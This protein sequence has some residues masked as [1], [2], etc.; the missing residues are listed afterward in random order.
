MP[1]KIVEF[2]FEEEALKDLQ[3]ISEKLNIR[4]GEVVR[5]ALSIE[6]TLCEMHLI[7]LRNPDV[8]KL[9]ASINF[10][11][12]QKLKICVERDN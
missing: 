11:G 4:T 2:A 3:N 9:S 1:E 6:K 7:F 10:D 5:Q 12:M 8:K